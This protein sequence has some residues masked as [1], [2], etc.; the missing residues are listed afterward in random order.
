MLIDQAVASYSETINAFQEELISGIENEEDE[1]VIEEVL[2]ILALLNFGR[3]VYDE[4]NVAET[5]GLVAGINTY[6]DF[7]D[8]LLDGLPYFGNPSEVQIQ[9][10]RRIHRN[11][12]NGVTVNVAESIRSSV[13]QGIIS[14]L[15]GDQ[16]RDLVRNNLKITVP[17]IDNMV[18]TMLSNYGR[19]VVLTMTDGLPPGTLYSYIGPRDNKNRP[20]CRQFLDEQPLTKAQIRDIKPDALENAGGANC[21]HFFIP[22]DVQV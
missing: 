15:D 21:R 8:N 13:S 22:E 5:M 1:S 19:A 3:L 12:I 7:S 17:R 14:N 11:A 18:G 16:I 20:V 9:A 10:L 6:M 2:V 4:D